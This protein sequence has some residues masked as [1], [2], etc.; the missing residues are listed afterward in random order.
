MEAAAHREIVELHRFFTD[1][2]RATLPRDEGDLA[3]FSGVMAPGM[4]FVSTSGAVVERAALVE[5]V[6]RGYGRWRDDPEAAIRIDGYRFLH[7]EGELGLAIY[8][9]SQ[10]A[11]GQR[12]SRRS[13]ALFRR[14]PAAP[15]GLEWL[16]VHETWIAGAESRR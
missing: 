1:W 8:E 14:Q 11:A 3:R 16:H 12:T 7:R 10:Q 2:F 4:V 13:T 15:N 5:G 6:R 9:E